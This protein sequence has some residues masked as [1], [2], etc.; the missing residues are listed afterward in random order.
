MLNAEEQTI[1]TSC[2]ERQ[3]SENGTH[4][5]DGFSPPPPTPLPIPP[6]L[7]NIDLLKRIA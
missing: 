2:L 1:L 4:D 6:L 7:L 5:S 3:E